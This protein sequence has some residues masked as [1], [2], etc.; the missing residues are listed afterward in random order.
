ML[1]R[2][3]DFQLPF[4]VVKRNLIKAPVNH[5]RTISNIS[6]DQA[7]VQ[8]GHAPG[9]HESCRQ[10]TADTTYISLFNSKLQIYRWRNVPARYINPECGLQGKIPVFNT[11]TVRPE[12]EML[13]G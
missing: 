8:P 5:D 6:T 13:A 3:T 1:D 7:P 9:R 2:K 11:K 4:I 12:F 10:V